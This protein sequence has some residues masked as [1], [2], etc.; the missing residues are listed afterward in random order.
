MKTLLYTLTTVLLLSFTSCRNDEDTP[1]YLEEDPYQAFLDGS[2]ITSSFSSGS[3]Y[4]EAGLKFKP[5]VNGELTK[6]FIKLPGDKQ[7][8]RITIWDVSSQEVL[9]TETFETITAGVEASKNITPFSLEKNKEYIVS[10]N[11]NSWYQ[12][13]NLDSSIPYPITVG[14]IVYTG[15]QSVPTT[16]QSYPSAS[17]PA[18]IAGDISFAFQRTE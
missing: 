18:A 9:R 12:R 4:H 8:V 7:N 17:H 10:F 1:K 11:S 16:E 13:N 5:T 6:L 2:G 15:F 14:S 3:G